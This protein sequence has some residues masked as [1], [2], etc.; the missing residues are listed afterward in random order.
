MQLLGMAWQ[1]TPHV[2][3]MALAKSARFKLLRVKFQY[4]AWIFVPSAPSN[5]KTAGA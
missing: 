3:A 1:S 4:H 2:V 5:F